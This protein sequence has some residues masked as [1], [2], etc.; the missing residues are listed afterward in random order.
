M[1]STISVTVRPAAL[2]DA[3]AIAVLS[4][5]LGYPATTSQCEERLRVILGS[6]EHAVTVACLD[7]GTVVGWVH[8]FV[9]HRVEF[10]PFAEIS[11]FVVAEQYRGQGVG[12]RLCAAAEAWTVARQ[13]PMVRVRS[14]SDRR[15]AR[16]FYAGLGFARTKEQNVFDK[17]VIKDQ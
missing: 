4:G 14:R 11:G 8:V 12:K 7:D 16:G 2:E 3:A 5:E 10:D 9:A 17:Y 1:K 13:I 6:D 15:A